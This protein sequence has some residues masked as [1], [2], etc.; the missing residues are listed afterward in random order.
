M[1]RLPYQLR[2]ANS[3]RHP[4]LLTALSP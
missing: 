2:Q 1:I 3:R 4:G